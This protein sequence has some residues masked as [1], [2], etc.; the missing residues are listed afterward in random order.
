M[1][2]FSSKSF[3]SLAFHHFTRH[4]SHEIFVNCAHYSLIFCIVFLLQDVLAVV[5][6]H[7]P[8]SSHCSRALGQLSTW[9]ATAET[10]TELCW[11]STTRGLWLTSK[12]CELIQTQCLEG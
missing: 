2:Q 11:L 12:P 3:Q 6:H 5:F 4:A 7:C 8:V 10:P 9:P 1:L